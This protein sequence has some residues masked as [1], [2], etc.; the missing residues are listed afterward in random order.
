MAHEIFV[1]VFVFVSVCS[2]IYLQAMLQ[3]SGSLLEDFFFHTVQKVCDSF[4]LY[5][6]TGGGGGGG[7]GV[8]GGSSQ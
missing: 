4:Q 3:L 5:C 2:L 6:A 7:G 1:F 8:G